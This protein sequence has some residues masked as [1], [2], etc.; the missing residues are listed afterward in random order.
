MN[1]CQGLHQRERRHIGG[2]RHDAETHE[3]GNRRNCQRTG[4]V[5]QSEEAR[6]QEQK[7]QHFGRNRLGPEHGGRG[8]SD[9]DIGPADHRKG[10]VHGMTAVNECGNDDD[11]YECPPA[12]QHAPG[13][14]RAP[15]IGSPW[16]TRG[17]RGH[18]DRGHRG[19][20]QADR[21]QPDHRGEPIETRDLSGQQRA[22]HERRRARAAHPAV[23]EPAGLAV[24][25]ASRMGERQ[26][27]GER[28]ERGKG[29]GLEQAD[30]HDHPDG[31]DRKI[32]QC[33]H[34]RENGEER[35]LGT[36]SVEAV[37][38]ASGERTEDEPHRGSCAEHQPE[39]FGRKTAQGQERRQERRD[40]SERAEEF[41][42]EKHE[43]EERAVLKGHGHPGAR[44]RAAVRCVS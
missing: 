10:I 12:K 39:V 9:A 23:L 1:P 28:H 22:E 36:K 4:R 29:S 16:R 37:S 42:I 13:D 41:G 32:R 15:G 7:D 3:A 21:A 19:R 31:A 25:C 44:A 2:L 14:A 38:E 5:E 34:R 6:T 33:G 26:R 30:D 24:A 40:Q 11:A 43:P 35:K 20:K 27:V 17:K 8:G 18:Q